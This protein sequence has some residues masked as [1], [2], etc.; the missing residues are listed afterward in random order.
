MEKKLN[1]IQYKILYTSQD[2]KPMP[3]LVRYITQLVML[4]ILVVAALARAMPIVTETALQPRNTPCPSKSLSI[5]LTTATVSLLQRS[6]CQPDAEGIIT[7]NCA[8]H[9]YSALRACF[10]LFCL[11]AFLILLHVWQAAKYKKIRTS[12][13]APF[14]RWLFSRREA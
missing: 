6:V 9:V 12:F 14:A 11:F 7:A 5:R 3:F 10:A 2:L 1:Q 13:V 4:S 8:P